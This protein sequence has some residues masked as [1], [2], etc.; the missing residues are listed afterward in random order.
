MTDRHASNIK[1]AEVLYEGVRGFELYLDFFPGWGLLAAE[2]DKDC[3]KDLYDTD[4][5]LSQSFYLDE[6]RF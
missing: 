1:F 4:V 6:R 3:L 2:D 5:G